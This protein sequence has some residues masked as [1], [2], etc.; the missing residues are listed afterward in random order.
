MKWPECKN[1][2]K[3]RDFLGMVGIVW[4]WIRGFAEV[5][6]PLTKLTRVMKGEFFWGEEQKLAMEKIKERVATCKAI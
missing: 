6:D 1:V 5:A 3:V 2:L 4:N